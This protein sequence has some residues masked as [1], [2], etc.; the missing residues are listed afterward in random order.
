MHEFLVVKLFVRLA[1]PGGPRAS[2]RLSF[3]RAHASRAEPKADAAVD[4]D[5]RAIR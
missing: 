3:S 1:P 5:E 4:R 2:A